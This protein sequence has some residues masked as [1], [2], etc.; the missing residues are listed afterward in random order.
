MTSLVFRIRKRYFEAIVAGE[1]TVEYR[2]HTDFW[3]KR[4]KGKTGLDTA[5]FICGKQV[6]RRKIL[7]IQLVRTRGWFS[8]QGK[9]DVST[10]YCYAI[11]LGSEV[12]KK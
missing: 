9:K 10:L 6:H 1:K 11:Y 12:T 8:D 2:P 7:K 5:V 3:E 4:I